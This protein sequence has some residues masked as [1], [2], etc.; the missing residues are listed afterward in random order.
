MDRYNYCTNVFKHLV[1]LFCVSGLLIQ[2]LISAASWSFALSVSMYR[3]VSQVWPQHAQYC[4]CVRSVRVHC[5]LKM[6]SSVNVVG[7]MDTPH[8]LSDFTVQ[9]DNIFVIHFFCRFLYLFLKAQAVLYIFF[10]GGK[11]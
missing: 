10:W 8:P 7:R 3:E 11:K 5:L 6:D 2:W 4:V 1:F 9:I